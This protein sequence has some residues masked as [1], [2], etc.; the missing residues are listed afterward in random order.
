MI[1][2]LRHLLYLP[3]LLVRLW[4][5][6]RRQKKFMQLTL[7][8]DL[9]ESEKTNDGSLSEFDYKKIR[10][11][12]GWAVPA[13]LGEAFCM[14]REASM[15]AQERYALTYLGALTGL[16]D[17]FFDE[18]EKPLEEIHEMLQRPET[19]K[20][21]S[22]HDKLFLCL[23][24]K[25]LTHCANIHLLKENAKPVID[26]QIKSKEQTK[27]NLKLTTIKKLTM[28]KGG[29]SLLFYRAA[30]TETATQAEQKMYYLLGGV[31]QLENDIFDIYKDRENGIQTL[32]TAST[33]IPALREQYVELMRE[34]QALVSDMHFSK[35]SKKNFLRFISLIMCRALVCLDFLE[36]AQETTRGIFQL[37]NYTRRQLICDMGK[38]ANNLKLLRYYMRYA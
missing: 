22:S 27:Q 2:A 19:C 33:Y 30:F 12:Y 37:H 6:S 28:D 34:T 15:Q 11:Y 29:Y 25:T 1:K 24:S 18:K 17:D 32:A 7:E 26:V 8:K 20:G 14:L 9:F 5:A 10:T 4:K 36:E 13:I 31:G 35:R 16:F 21:T 23:Y 3:I 38:F